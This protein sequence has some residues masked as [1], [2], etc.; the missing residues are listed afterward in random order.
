[1]ST[2]TEPLELWAML[3][4]P[5]DEDSGRVDHDSLARYARAMADRGCHGLVAL[6]IIAEPQTLSIPEQQRVLATVTASTD[7]PVY[8]SALALDEDTRRRVVPELVSCTDRAPA[9]LMVPVD[10]PDPVELRRRV[11]DVHRRAGDL[12]IVVQDYP[13]WSGVAIGVDALADALDGLDFVAAVKCEAPPTFARIRRLR[14]RMPSARCISGL[15]GLSLVDDLEQGAT[16]A[17]CGV[18]RPEVV[19]AALDHYAAGRPDLARRMIN[20]IA[21]SIGF[22]VQQGTSIAVRKEGLRRQGLFAHAAVRAPTRPYDVWLDPLLQAHERLV[23]S[24]LALVALPTSV[25]A[26]VL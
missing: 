1:M 24:E 17:A 10:T 14:Q 13:A 5:F 11:I 9:G 2:Q 3:A 15:G 20:V 8:A 4:T 22:E 21:S 7:V 23:A 18:T 25:G 16:V 6:G 19:G 12:P 26:S